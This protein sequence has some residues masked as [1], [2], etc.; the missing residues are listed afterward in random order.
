MSSFTL[1]Q[2]G[3]IIVAQY[4]DDEAETHG[5]RLTFE[6]MH[7]DSR[8]N[9]TGEI[10]VTNPTRMN[11]HIH[12]S[13]VSMLG[14]NSR[15][16]LAKRCE[17][18][19]IGPPW[20]AIMEAV[21][22]SVVDRY[23]AGEPIVD[24]SQHVR[25]EGLFYRV[26][27]YV[28]EHEA[29]V[30]FGD[31]G[32]GK[33]MMATLF[34]VLVNEGWVTEYMDIEPGRV[35]YLDWETDEDTFQERCQMIAQGLGMSD[36]RYTPSVLYRRMTA[37]LATDIEPIQ[38]A[39][40][41]YGVDFVIVDSGGPACG[42]APSDPQAVIGLFMA[43]RSLKC[44]SLTLTHVSKGS[45]DNPI[46]SVYWTN[47]ARQM[48]GMAKEQE[49]E[50]YTTDIL[51]RHAKVNNGRVLSP[52]AYRLQ[53]MKENDLDR[54]DAVSFKPIV[55]DPA[56]ALGKGLPPDKRI[57]AALVNES[58]TVDELSERFDDLTKNS[59]TAALAQG[60]FV[61]LGQGKWGVSQP[62]PVE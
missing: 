2:M 46:G 36:S 56:S 14:P 22:V 9:V 15:R 47:Y 24:I 37:S 41:E 19:Y 54:S 51:L 48:W 30:I 3:G 40:A 39:V 43:L 59:I 38:K 44:T 17:E 20:A 18:I 33:S 31:G 1:E 45:A 53:F 7:Q 29:N 12:K 62:M 27:P 50:S 8:G 28:M 61:N 5:L 11:P 42:G 60:S 23:R 10:T 6:R 57:T 32:I 52:R 55:V 13:R 26:R 16:D 34:A 4:P 49:P 35:L 21:V 25:K 58:L